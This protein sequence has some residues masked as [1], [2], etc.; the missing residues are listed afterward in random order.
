MNPMSMMSPMGG[1]TGMGGSTMGYQANYTL[2][3]VPGIGGGYAYPPGSDMCK[4]MDGINQT[5]NNAC[6]SPTGQGSVMDWANGLAMQAQMG[7][8][9]GTSGMSGMSGMGGM[10]GG[11]GGSLGQL[12]SMLM[13]MMSMF[14]QLMGGGS[15]MP[16]M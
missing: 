14:Q 9:G 3:G 12:Q 8:M 10:G 4:F 16:Q 2:N 6:A 15:Q 13:Y 11:L 7:G 1:I 5:V